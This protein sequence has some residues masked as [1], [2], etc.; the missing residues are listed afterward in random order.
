MIS[1][2]LWVKYTLAGSFDSVAFGPLDSELLARSRPQFLMV[3]PLQ[4]YATWQL[5]SLEKARVC[6]NKMKALGFFLKKSLY[7]IGA[8]LINS[9]VLVSGIQQI[10]LLYICMLSIIFQTLFPI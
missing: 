10:D 5:A 6:T 9:I 3:R 4:L 8:Q 2:F 1:Q 7:F